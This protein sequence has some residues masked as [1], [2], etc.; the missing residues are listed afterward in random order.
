MGL[1]IK[2]NKKNTFFIFSLI[3]I[4]SGII[5]SYALV[6][7]PSH[8]VEELINVQSKIDTSC[9]PGKAINNI[10]PNGDI[11]CIDLIPGPPGSLD[12]EW[13]GFIYET[14]DECYVGMTTFPTPHEC[15]AQ[16][17]T[18]P[19]SHRVYRCESDGSWNYIGHCWENGYNGGAN[20]PKCE[21]QS[22]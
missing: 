5:F 7:V 3:L 9:F 12:C 19:A 14:G 16:G 17:L 4:V 8:S 10:D 2:L 1:K 6:V 21:T 15:L 22:W 18:P 11:D 20:P 13:N